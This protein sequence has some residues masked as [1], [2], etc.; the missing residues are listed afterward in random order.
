MLL[1]PVPPS[2]GAPKV[3]PAA[4]CSPMPADLP[5]AASVAR[6]LARANEL[7]AGGRAQLAADVDA[8]FARHHDQLYAWCLRWV[9][10][11][12]LAMDLAQDTLLTAYQKLATFR[13]DARFSTWLLRIARFKSLNALR[14]EG[15]VLAE[16]GLIDPEDPSG[17]ALTHLQRRQ[18]E[19]L[20]REA[21]AAVLDPLEQEVIYLRY[22][23]HLPVDR[24]TDLL[25]I[26][27]AT[28]ARGLLQRCKRKLR[29]ELLRRLA[30][31][32]HGT[33]FVRGTL[34]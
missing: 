16:D 5:E 21:A 4:V 31:M 11:P 9:G 14:K 15:E 24:I 32:D 18:R 1:A 23:E 13:G 27:T 28:G 22:T 25:E 26:D 34:S 6:R 30:E 7:D 12:E 10:D 17:S 20:M 33:S 19:D 8:L 2:D 3:A 29:D